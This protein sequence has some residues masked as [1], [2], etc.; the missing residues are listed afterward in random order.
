M[1][2]WSFPPPPLRWYVRG[3]VLTTHVSPKQRLVS[4]VRSEETGSAAPDEINMVRESF[5]KR[6]HLHVLAVGVPYQLWVGSVELGQHR[7]MRFAPFL[8]GQVTHML[9]PVAGSLSLAITRGVQSHR[10][11][12]LAAVNRQDVAAIFV[13]VAATRPTG[14]VKCAGD[15]IEVRAARVLL[16]SLLFDDCASLGRDF[17]RGQLLSSA[18]AVVSAL[19]SSLEKALL[20]TSGD[21]SSLLAAQ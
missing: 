14:G 18:L 13:G 9:P 19:V 7:L 16:C 10:G 1:S 17:R 4:E 15:Q 6:H 20:L 12:A 3:G 11:A 2:A 8:F 21:S 5:L